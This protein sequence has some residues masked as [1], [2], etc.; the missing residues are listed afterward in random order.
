VANLEKK[1]Y[2]IPVEDWSRRTLREPA[3]GVM[4]RRRS[5]QSSDSESRTAGLAQQPA[6]PCHSPT[7]TEVRRGTSD[8]LTR[9]RWNRVERGGDNIER[10]MQEIDPVNLRMSSRKWEKLGLLLSGK[11]LDHAS[12][13]GTD[14]SYE[15][16][17]ESMMQMFVGLPAEVITQGVKDT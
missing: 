16:N 8:G 13:Y 9:S 6:E 10:S 1:M 4:D 5:C 2:Q 11:T 17:A 15:E 7:P 14:L 3:A 12:M